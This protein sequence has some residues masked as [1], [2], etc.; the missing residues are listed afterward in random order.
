MSAL[1]I[2]AIRHA[3][4]GYNEKE[5]INGTI[6][7]PL[8]KRGLQQI[9]GII[10]SLKDYRLSMVYA[11]PLQRSLQTATPIAARYQ[12]PLQVDARLLEVNLGSFNGQGWD[13]TIPAFGLN[14][15]G[16]LSSCEYDFTPYGGESAAETRERVQSFLSDLKAKGQG[17][18]LIVCHGGI[19]RWFYYLCTGQKA[20]RIPNSSVHIFEL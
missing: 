8:S 6:D 2:I 10:D 19:L 4:T 13:A 1:K 11:S 12:L 14:S 17:T 16:V 5:L 3:I 9:P 15:S 18:P 20:G 7:E